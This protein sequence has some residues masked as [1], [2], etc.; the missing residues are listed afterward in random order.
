MTAAPGEADDRE[1]A[2]HVLDRLRA[3]GQRLAVAESCT[4][5]LLGGALT[6]VPGASD[7][8]WGGAVAYADRAKVELLGVSEATLA[9]AGAVSEAVAREMAEGVRRRGGVDW[10]LS[11][12]GVAG[13]GGGSEEKPVGTVWIAAAGPRSAARRHRFPGGRTEVRER[14]V[15]A[16]LE[17]LR[18]LGGEERGA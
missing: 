14:S 17:L 15:R 4:G 5:G 3:A 1:L 12:T 18:R 6:E 2:E 7:V 16:A 10:G 9:D 8:F 13:P 11:I